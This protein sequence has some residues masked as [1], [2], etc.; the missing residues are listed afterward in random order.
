MD[1]RGFTLVEMMMTV[2]IMAA[3]I[4]LATMQFG[5]MNQKS[6]VESQ[7]KM[8]FGDLVAL[9]SQALYKRTTRSVVILP[10]KFSTYSS[11]TTSGSALNQRVL[12][13][14]VI[15]SNAAATQQINFDGWGTATG[16]PAVNPDP[17][18]GLSI[19]VAADNQGAYDSVVIT[20]LRISMGKL[21]KGAGCSIANIVTN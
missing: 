9:R 10:A 14:P 16:S 3:L 18:T 8:L 19:C 2:C 5:S 11:A 7:T 1:Q 21:T 4:A 17:S 12:T 13:Y 20:S 6:G 15:N